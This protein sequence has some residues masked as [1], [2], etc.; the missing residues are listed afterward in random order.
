MGKVLDKKDTES[1]ASNEESEESWEESGREWLAKFNTMKVGPPKG[2]RH[3]MG[4]ADAVE[5][6]RLACECLSGWQEKKPRR[7][8]NCIV[9]SEHSCIS[10]LTSTSACQYC[11]SL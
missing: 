4:Q 7:C 6:D 8:L 1:S 5:V 11:R 3:V 2:I 10:W 9:S